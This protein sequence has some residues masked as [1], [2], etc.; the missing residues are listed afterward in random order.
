MED[1]EI[2][3]QR[4]QM[5]TTFIP[6]NAQ[7]LLR[8]DPSWE[9]DRAWQSLVD[10]RPVPIDRDMVLSMGKDPAQSVAVPE[11]WGLGKDKYFGRVD[12]FQ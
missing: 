5:P 8:A 10:T 6:F 11:S 1:I 2:K 7:D 12:V 3:V 9:V 4:K